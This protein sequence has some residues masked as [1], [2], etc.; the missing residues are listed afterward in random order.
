MFEDLKVVSDFIGEDHINKY[1]YEY[2]GA[3]KNI[4][5]CAKC[6]VK[7]STET[8]EL[9][10]DLIKEVEQ[11]LTRLVNS[12]PMSRADAYRYIEKRIAE[13]K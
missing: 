6:I 8:L 3:C 2:S 9:D 5:S 12:I 1:S 4:V 10:P 7:S 13:N 11:V